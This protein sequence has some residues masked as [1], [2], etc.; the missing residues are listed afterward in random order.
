LRVTGTVVTLTSQTPDN[1]Q[2]VI[3]VHGVRLV[4][5]E[6]RTAFTTLAQFLELGIDPRACAIVAVKLGY[7]FPELRAI[8]RAAY[9]AT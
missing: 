6:R 8:A 7:L 2:A 1:R 3:D 9:L 5:T 4:L